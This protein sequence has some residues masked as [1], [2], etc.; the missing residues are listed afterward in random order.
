MVECMHNINTKLGGHVVSCT[1]DG[2]I[3]DIEDLESKLKGL[4]AEN[5]VLFN[6]F[7]ES[8]RRLSDNAECLE[9]K[10]KVEA[11]GLMS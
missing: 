2:F 6:L 1:T 10:T 4:P 7:R 9:L 8:G 5:T 3:T 11:D